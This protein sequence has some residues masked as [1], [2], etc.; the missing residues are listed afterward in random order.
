MSTL[1]VNNITPQSGTTLTLGGSGD[2]INLGSGASGLATT[3]GTMGVLI[4]TT[5]FS[6][7]S[8]QAINSVFSS[9]YDN[10]RFILN[11]TAATADADLYLRLRNGTTDKSSNYIFAKFG[12][13]STSG[14]VVSGSGAGTFFNLD[15]VDSTATYSSYSGDILNPFNSKKTIALI[16]MVNLATD[17]QN[18]HQNFFSL[19]TE[20]YSA[21]GLNLIA[22]AGA[23]TGTIS[24]YGYNK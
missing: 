12:R 6:A 4:N 5:S 16:S 22:S 9:T 18:Y 11:L 3:G 13:Q 15:S 1:E 10:Y 17:N 24:I 8:S 14:G 19:Q 23:I 2:T 7:V 21:D 20:D